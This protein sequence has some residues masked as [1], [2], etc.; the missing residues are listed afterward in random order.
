MSTARFSED[1]E[2]DLLD[3]DERSWNAAWPTAWLTPMP[4]G[5]GA[6]LKA[7]KCSDGRRNLF[8]TFAKKVRNGLFCNSSVLMQMYLGLV[9][10]HLPSW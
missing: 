4:C 9:N 8:L 6:M 10:T 3:S 2:A 5:R 7:G 1:A